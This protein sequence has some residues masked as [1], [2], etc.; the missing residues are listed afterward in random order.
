MADTQS[1]VLSPTQGETY[2]AGPFDI[3]A[4]VLGAQSGGAFE[5]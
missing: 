4:R 5:L 1:F 2:A 3:T